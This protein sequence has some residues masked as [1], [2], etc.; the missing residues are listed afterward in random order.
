MPPSGIDINVPD[1]NLI[2]TSLSVLVHIDVDWEMC[3]DVS[4]LVLEA[5]CDSD[6]QVVDEGSDSS[7]GSDVLSRTV[8]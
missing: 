5:L 1:L 7:E 3:I 6:D 2:Q 8:V 4:H